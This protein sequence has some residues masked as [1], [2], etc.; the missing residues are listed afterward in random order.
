MAQSD[1][2][3]INEFRNAFLACV[4]RF[5][6]VLPLLPVR[7]RDR[8]PMMTA[9]REIEF[10]MRSILD[11]SLGESRSIE[12]L[13]A[14]MK[15]V[16]TV[17]HLLDQ[18]ETELFLHEIHPQIV[19]ESQFLESIQKLPKATLAEYLATETVETPLLGSELYIA[20]PISLLYGIG[21]KLARIKWLFDAIK[22]I[23]AVAITAAAAAG[24]PDIAATLTKILQKMRLLNIAMG[25]PGTDGVQSGVSGGAQCIVTVTLKKLTIDTNALGTDWGFVFDTRIENT[26]QT[27][28]FNNGDLTMAASATAGLFEFASMPQVLAGPVTEGNCGEQVA[29]EITMT[30]IEYD[31]VDQNDVG[32]DSDIWEA[33]CDDTTETVNLQVTVFEGESV[34]GVLTA[35]IDILRKCEAPETGA[36]RSS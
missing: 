27:R 36:A 22:K 18:L 17:N 11:I 30:A 23:L 7:P 13:A 20:T 35:E 19:T 10:L 31:T 16:G 25:G 34:A 3:K 8:F 9:G 1:E 21:D 24:R 5:S 4:S 26:R 32:R 14:V 12:H 28:R 29:V 33:I 15:G 6:S 2:K